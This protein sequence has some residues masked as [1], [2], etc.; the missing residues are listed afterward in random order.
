MCPIFRSGFSGASGVYPRRYI[1]SFF[2]SLAERKASAT[3]SPSPFF[4]HYACLR[5]AH[6]VSPASIRA[7]TAAEKYLALT[8][9]SSTQMGIESS[10]PESFSRLQPSIRACQKL[11]RVWERRGTAGRRGFEKGM[12]TVVDRQ[13]V[14]D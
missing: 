6:P 9:R 12:P 2:F 10:G 3:F 8:R 4:F 13:T 1:Y 11:K 7:E 5:D 14:S